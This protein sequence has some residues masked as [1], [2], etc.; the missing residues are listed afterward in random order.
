MGGGALLGRVGDNPAAATLS[1]VSV[2]DDVNEGTKDASAVTSVSSAIAN[3]S[4]V[5]SCDDDVKGEKE[6]LDDAEDDLANK[7]IPEE[8][9]VPL[10]SPKR[11]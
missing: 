7:R 4:E 8:A 10:D 1:S 3:V 11:N 5:S 6:P 9:P 2:A